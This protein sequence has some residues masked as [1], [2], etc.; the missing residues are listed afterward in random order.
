MNP[1]PEDP[2]FKRKQDSTMKESN[3][4]CT[5][6]S[7]EQNNWHSASPIPDEETA[8]QVAKQCLVTISCDNCDLCLMFCPDL[9]MTR[10]IE[11]GLIE[12]DYNY[13][14]GCGICAFICPKNAINMIR[15]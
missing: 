15:E 13:C 4:H 14:K 11:T 12:I 1:S 9:C 10:N 3:Q 5:R 7:I 8:V 6:Y 2:N